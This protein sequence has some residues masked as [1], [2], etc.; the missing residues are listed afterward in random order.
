[1]PTDGS[2]AAAVDPPPPNVTTSCGSLA[3]SLLWKMALLVPSIVSPRLTRPLPATA[4]G[5]S[6]ISL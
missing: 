5:L 3:P 1:M 4:D 2:D 6:T